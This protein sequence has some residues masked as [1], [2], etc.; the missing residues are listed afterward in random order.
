MKSIKKTLA[1]LS[2]LTLTFSLAA[3]GNGGESGTDSSEAVTTTTGV[4]VE[5]NTAT[6][7]EE[8]SNTLEQAAKENLRDIEL[9]NKT[10]KWLAHY[11]INPSTSQGGST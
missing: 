7:N 1:G 3:C 9:E 5:L 11:D 4:T 2:A 10:I 6:L 8:D